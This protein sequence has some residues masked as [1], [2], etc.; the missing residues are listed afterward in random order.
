VLF[1]GV[2]DGVAH[3]AYG[4][5]EVTERWGVCACHAAR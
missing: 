4:A 1:H 5:V 3:D 2:A